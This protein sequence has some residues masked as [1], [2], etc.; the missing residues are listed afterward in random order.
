MG[1]NSSEVKKTKAELKTFLSLCPLP[2]ALLKSTVKEDEGMSYIFLYV[3]MY[4]NT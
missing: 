2:K 4:K 3:C 1:R